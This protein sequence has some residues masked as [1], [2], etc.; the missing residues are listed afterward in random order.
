MDIEQEL[1]NGIYVFLNA[2]NKN[3]SF[4]AQAILAENIGRLLMTAEAS[5]RTSFSKTLLKLID[6]YLQELRTEVEGQIEGNNKTIYE[7]DT[8]HIGC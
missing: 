1:A 2:R 8:E 5:G 7:V 6:K 3:K 4:M